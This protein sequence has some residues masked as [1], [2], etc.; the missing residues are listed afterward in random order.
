MRMRI[1]LSALITAVAVAT[2]IGGNVTAASAD[3]SS[4]YSAV[5]NSDCC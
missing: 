2:T 1:A 4:L 3:A 5:D